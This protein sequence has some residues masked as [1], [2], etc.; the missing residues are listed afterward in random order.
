MAPSTRPACIFRDRPAEFKRAV[1]QDLKTVKSYNYVFSLLPSTTEDQLYSVLSL[2]T[3]NHCNKAHFRSTRISS[4]CL[5]YRPGADFI[6]DARL[7]S[8]FLNLYLQVTLQATLTKYP[9]SRQPLLRDPAQSPSL[10]WAKLK[11]ETLPDAPAMIL[12]V[13]AEDRK[14]VV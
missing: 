1:L 6:N 13:K 8:L 12:T 4:C 2:S 3:I 7:S 5:R 14:S 10:N 11:Q 9:L